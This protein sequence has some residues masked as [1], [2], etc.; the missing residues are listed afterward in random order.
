MPLGLDVDLMGRCV[1]WGPAPPPFPKRRRSPVAEVGLG[2]VQ[3]VLDGPSHKTG[4]PPQ[5]SAHLY[6]G[7]T[8]RCIKMQDAIWY[9][10]RP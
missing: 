7:Q 5:F 1:K 9:G 6:C 8:A 10:G 4:P 2:P 3:I